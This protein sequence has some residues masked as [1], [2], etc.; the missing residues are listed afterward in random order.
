MHPSLQK[1][2]ENEGV[3]MITV[4][5][6]TRNQM[7]KGNADW[8]FVKKV[9]KVKIPVVVNGDVNEINDYYESKYKSGSDLCN[10]RQRFIWKTMDF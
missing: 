2:F 6:R 4:H 8:S 7:F 9:K 1:F 5:G 3:K 10:D